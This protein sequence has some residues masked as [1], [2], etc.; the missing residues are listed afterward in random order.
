V[1]LFEGL[2]PVEP[3]IKKHAHILSSEPG[4]K[5][6]ET[7]SDL[8]NLLWT[9]MIDEDGRN[10]MMEPNGTERYPDF[11]LYKVIAA[12]VHDAVPSEQITRPIFDKFRVSKEKV[13]K[14]TK[15][16]NLFC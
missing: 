2:F 5:I 3:L 12:K 11:E 1:S 4:L 10:V 15:V 14:K 9:W 6:K 16:Y 8:Y 7:E 13:S